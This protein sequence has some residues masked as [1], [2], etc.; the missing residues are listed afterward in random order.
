MTSPLA[1][2]ARPAER[3]KSLV[4]SAAAE[5]SENWRL[6]EEYQRQHGQKTNK[7]RAKAPKPPKPPRPQRHGTRYRFKEGCRCEP[8]VEANRA[9]GRK[10]KRTQA[11][12]KAAAKA[13][14]GPCPCRTHELER[15]VLGGGL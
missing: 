15:R 10:F 4:E 3:F 7:S 14:A 1:I 8:C 11:A 2:W 9:E 6:W 12:K 13:A 5:R